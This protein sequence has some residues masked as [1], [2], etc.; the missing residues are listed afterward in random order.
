MVETMVRVLSLPL[1]FPEIWPLRTGDG[2]FTG[3]LFM[4]LPRMLFSLH[5][6]WQQKEAWNLYRFLHAVW[7]F[8]T[9]CGL[10]LAL[11]NP[12]QGAFWGAFLQQLH[13]G[14]TGALFLKQGAKEK[15]RYLWRKGLLLL[16]GA[17]WTF[18]ISFFMI[19]PEP[20]YWMLWLVALGVLD[21]IYPQ[22]SR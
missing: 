17:A 4:T 20:I 6:I 8:G 5:R 9:L 21:A 14:V 12:D 18:C 19:L 3:F 10:G 7:I 22:V 2:L 13:M 15:Q 16:T 1:L 11:T